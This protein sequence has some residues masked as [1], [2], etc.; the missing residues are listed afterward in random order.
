M[1]IKK[2]NEVYSLLICHN[3]QASILN[4]NDARRIA[5]HRFGSESMLA[6]YGIFTGFLITTIF[7]L[8]VGNY[9]VQ[10][11]SLYIMYMET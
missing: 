9:L 8:Y 1:F 11:L 4:R 5:H 7:V 2:A 6:R 10:P 3:V